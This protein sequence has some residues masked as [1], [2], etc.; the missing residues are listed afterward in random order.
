[1]GIADLAARIV[2]M[3]SYALR[4]PFLTPR[5]PPAASMCIDVSDFACAQSGQSII[6]A[7]TKLCP[8]C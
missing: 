6:D 4:I 3:K 7:I 2:T 1:M 5:D 8:D